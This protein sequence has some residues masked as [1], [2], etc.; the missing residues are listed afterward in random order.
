MDAL[1][2]WIFNFFPVLSW[3]SIFLVGILYFC[4]SEF[5]DFG[6]ILRRFGGVYALTVFLFALFLSV[7]QYLA[8]AGDSTA[9]KFLPPI[10]PI[11]YFL[12]YV[13]IRF[14]LPV[15]ISFLIAGLWYL[16]LNFLRRYQ[17]RF[18]ENGEPE[19]GF[20]LALFIGWPKFLVF[21]PI[22]FLCVVL[23]SVFRMVVLREVYTTLGW[24][25]ILSALLNLFYGN[26]LLILFGLTALRVVSSY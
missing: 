26:L 25:L 17:D 5:K 3:V 10:Q 24:P 11:T 1:A 20:A 6:L 19:L 4:R 7:G 13:W 23:V 12:G 18:F 21:I 9:V 8:W 2:V 22:A 15:F 14:L 16:I